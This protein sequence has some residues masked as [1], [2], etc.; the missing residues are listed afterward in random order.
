MNEDDENSWADEFGEHCPKLSMKTRITL[1]AVC[2]GVGAFLAFLGGIFVFKIATQPEIFAILY[3]GGN[4]MA[5]CATMFLWGP[6]G[7]CRKMWDKSRWGAT[8]IY[9]LSMAA[10]I[11][12][13]FTV[14]I[15]YNVI[16]VIL[17]LIV[18]F[19]AMVWY[20]A[21]YIPCGRKVLA[22]IVRNVCFCGQV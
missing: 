20:S 4:L 13:A 8:L 1:W 17:C 7:Q 2:T 3:T 11:T 5:I 12:V 16:A 22:K 18:Q 14:P 9:F 6:C 10:T 21:S 15:P 19:C